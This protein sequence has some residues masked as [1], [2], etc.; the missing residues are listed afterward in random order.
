[1]F[2]PGSYCCKREGMGTQHKYGNTSTIPSLTG[3][4]EEQKHHKEMATEQTCSGD[5]YSNMGYF[6][7]RVVVLRFL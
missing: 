5:D 2:I 4:N 3:G 7:G 6:S 1:M